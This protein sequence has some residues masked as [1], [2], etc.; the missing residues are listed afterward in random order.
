MFVLYI[1]RDSKK[2]CNYTAKMIKRKKK[3]VTLS[4]NC[5]FNRE[6]QNIDFLFWTT[7]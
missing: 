7:I 3:K 5:S 2:K 6:D 4:G 1:V